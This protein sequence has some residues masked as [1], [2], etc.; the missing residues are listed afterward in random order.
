MRIKL[1]L[2][3]ETQKES[4]DDEYS[5]W[6]IKRN[7]IVILVKLPFTRMVKEANILREWYLNIIKN[8]NK[9]GGIK[10]IKVKLTIYDEKVNLKL[11]G[12]PHE[13][14][15]LDIWTM[16]YACFGDLFLNHLPRKDRVLYTL[17]RK[18]INPP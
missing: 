17:I 18:S 12:S 2:K 15:C 11:V 10:G 1:R 13:K 6:Y 9:K 16:D 3:M 5:R 7:E 8:V 4:E 14:D